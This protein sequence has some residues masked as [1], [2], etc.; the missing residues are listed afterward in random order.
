MKQ[1]GSVRQ[2]EVGRVEG[3]MIRPSSEAS[4]KA[5]ASSPPSVDSQP[6]LGTKE[7]NAESA[8]NLRRSV[9]EVLTDPKIWAF[10]T[11]ND[12]NLASCSGDRDG[13]AHDPW[14]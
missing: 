5:A 2:D 3:Q 12:E 6:P 7:D 1:G 10:S 13:A 4:L 14:R 9:G 11:S 8:S